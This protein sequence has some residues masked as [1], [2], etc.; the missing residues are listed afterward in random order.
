MHTCVMCDT[1]I[2]MFVYIKLHIYMHIFG[3]MQSYACIHVCVDG[4]MYVC[5]SD[6]CV[7]VHMYV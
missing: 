3:Y 5:V 6:T 1:C 4:W 2:S 7:Y